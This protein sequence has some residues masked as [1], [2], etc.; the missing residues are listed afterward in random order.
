M[1]LIW[2]QVRM[3]LYYDYLS[4]Y[5]PAARN[6]VLAFFGN[7]SSQGIGHIRLFLVEGRILLHD[8]LAAGDGPDD[9]DLNMALSLY[10]LAAPIKD[11]ERY[12][13][14]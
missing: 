2:C 13:H 1:A 7:L 3:D 8:K 5:E 9:R 6:K 11:S 14:F 12:Y 10:Y 4:Q